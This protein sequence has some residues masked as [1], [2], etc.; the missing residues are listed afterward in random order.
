[1]KEVEVVGRR[2]G[3]GAW[4]YFQPGQRNIQLRGAPKDDEV[5]IEHR[6]MT[7]RD[8]FA[9]FC[10]LF[11]II[12]EIVSIGRIVSAFQTPADLVQPPRFPEKVRSES[13]R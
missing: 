8:G 6:G 7:S 3:R 9:V 5:P 10:C 11:L 13:A 12:S 1:M 4:P 2:C